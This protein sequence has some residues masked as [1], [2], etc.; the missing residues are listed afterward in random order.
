MEL[1]KFITLLHLLQVDP[2]SIEVIKRVARRDNSLGPKIAA[3]LYYNK[4]LWDML[5]NP[6]P[7]GEESI[8]PDGS[9]IRFIM[10]AQ[11]QYEE[12]IRSRLRVVR[13]G[14]IRSVIIRSTNEYHE[15]ESF[16]QGFIGISCVWYKK[17]YVYQF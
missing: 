8:Q 5:R 15:E 6:I 3:W 9:Y 2:Q 12:S 17:Q 13:T 7:R 1:K 14:Q 10:I 4:E 11:A 16:P